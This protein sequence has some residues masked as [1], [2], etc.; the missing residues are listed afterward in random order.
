[1]PEL[2]LSAVRGK[3]ESVLMLS[4]KPSRGPR[5]GVLAE[6]VPDGEAVRNVPLKLANSHKEADVQLDLFPAES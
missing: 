1:M 6:S 5:E 4:V 3:R 2:V